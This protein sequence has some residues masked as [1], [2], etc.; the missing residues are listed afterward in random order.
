M[1][2]FLYFLTAVFALQQGYIGVYFLLLLSLYT[3]C[4]GEYFLFCLG[5]GIRFFAAIAPSVRG[6]T[7]VSWLQVSSVSLGVSFALSRQV[8]LGRQE[9]IRLK[10]LREAEQLTADM[11]QARLDKESFLAEEAR[12]REKEMRKRQVCGENQGSGGY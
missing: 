8:H 9:Q 4:F 6:F 12:E 3:S 11:E 5:D 1:E 10:A 2:A 7:G